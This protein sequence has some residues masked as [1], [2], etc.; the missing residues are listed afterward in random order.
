MNT[1]HLCIRHLTHLTRYCYK[2]GKVDDSSLHRASYQDSVDGMLPKNTNEFSVTRAFVLV[3]LSRM[4]RIESISS[5][6]LNELI[7]FIV[8]E[9]LDNGCKGPA[10]GKPFITGS[11]EC[12]LS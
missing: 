3:F 11:E 5:V 12:K 7:Y 4:P 9:L 2:E 10:I 8:D 1:G 6:V